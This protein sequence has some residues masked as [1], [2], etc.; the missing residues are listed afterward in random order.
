MVERAALPGVQV[1]LAP[2]QSQPIPGQT[3]RRSL[4]HCSL[5]CPEKGL[6]ASIQCNVGAVSCSSLSYSYCT[7]DKVGYSL[8]KV[9]SVLSQLP[10]AL[11]RGQ[12]E[13]VVVDVPEH[14]AH[15]KMQQTQKMVGLRFERSHGFPRRQQFG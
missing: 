4:M 1:C 8:G 3:A 13:V 10:L 7:E 9:L 12:Q 14:D 11:S 5:P 15:E 6:C 2:S